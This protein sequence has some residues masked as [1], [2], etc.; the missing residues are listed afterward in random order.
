MIRK[1]QIT[2]RELNRV[3]PEL[4]EKAIL[5]LG[6]YKDENSEETVNILIKELLKKYM[7]SKI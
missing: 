1:Q 6:D 3:Y 5:L 2:L 4:K 7:V